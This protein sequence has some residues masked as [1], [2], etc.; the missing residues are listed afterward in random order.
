MACYH[1]SALDRISTCNHLVICCC[2][3]DIIRIN[4]ML[5]LT[6]MK[7]WLILGY[8]LTLLWM[9]FTSENFIQRLV[10]KLFA[11]IEYLKNDSCR[12]LAHTHTGG[13]SDKNFFVSLVNT[14]LLFR[15][16][17]CTLWANSLCSEQYPQF[18]VCLLAKIRKITYTPAN[19]TFSFI[20][21]SSPGDAYSR[22]CSRQFL[23]TLRPKEILL[24]LSNISFGNNVFNIIWQIYLS[25]FRSFRF[26]LICL[27]SRLLQICFRC[28]RVKW[29]LP[30]C[31]LLGLDGHQ[32]E[33]DP[34]WK[35]LKP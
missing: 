22:H 7:E 25:V 16:K 13:N 21:S 35:S 18:T 29:G 32:H 23:K 2:G 17:I 4:E 11:N 24:K 34:F 28:W 5:N 31:S 10:H 15:W 1:F 9:Y 6:L 14:G 3:S 26:L 33:T 19:P 20:N 12:K 27:K 8:L 30:G